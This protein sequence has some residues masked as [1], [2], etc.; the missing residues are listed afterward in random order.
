MK[1]NS[2]KVGVVSRI[3]AVTV[4]TTED[5][6]IWT[7]CVSV[8]AGRNLISFGTISEKRFGVEQTGHFGFSPAFAKELKILSRMIKID[9]VTRR[10]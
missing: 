2:L 4:E 9:G 8:H 5:C 7:T 3:F 10:N 6:A 1:K